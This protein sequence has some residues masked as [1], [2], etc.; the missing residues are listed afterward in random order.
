MLKSLF[1][2]LLIASTGRAEDGGSLSIEEK[3]P[4][5]ITSTQQGYIIDYGDGRIASLFDAI[6]PVTTTTLPLRQIENTCDAKQVLANCKWEISFAPTR[7]TLEWVQ[8]PDKSRVGQVVLFYQ[9]SDSTQR[10]PFS[11]ES[12]IFWTIAHHENIFQQQFNS[13]PDRIICDNLDWVPGKSNKLIIDSIDSE[14]MQQNEETGANENQ[15]AGVAKNITLQVQ[16]GTTLIFEKVE[17]TTFP[18]PLG[19]IITFSYRDS[20]NQICQATFEA[21]T[22]KATND[23]R[24]AQS[25]KNFFNKKPI[26]PSQS[27]PGSLFFFYLISPSLKE[28]L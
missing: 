26:Y 4:P 6:G 10:V 27:L 28:V 3:A 13:K 7:R 22:A 8:H 11:D 15:G 21:S 25:N 17:S 24:A 5:K 19:Q 12:F 16:N 9:N 1:L 18:P 20:A 2:I 14:A 23:L